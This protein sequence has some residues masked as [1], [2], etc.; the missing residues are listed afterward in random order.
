MPT[1]LD[2]AIEANP[3]LELEIREFHRKRHDWRFETVDHSPPSDSSQANRQ[4]R[5]ILLH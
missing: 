2:V 1:P 4:P 5:L 3:N